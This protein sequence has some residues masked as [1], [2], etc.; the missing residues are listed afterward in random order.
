MT[1]QG[2][3]E[4]IGARQDQVA[5]TLSQK[6]L[7]Y[8]LGR[9]VLLSDQPLIDRMVKGGGDAPIS[10]MIIEIAVSRQ[11]RYRRGGQE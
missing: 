11:F 1:M 6:L 7:G 10:R 9:T 5:R 8:A 2:L 4:H 3:L